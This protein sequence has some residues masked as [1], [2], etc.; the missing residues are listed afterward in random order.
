MVDWHFCQISWVFQYCQNQNQNWISCGNHSKLNK[1]SKSHYTL[2]IE[3]ITLHFINWANHISL[4]KLI[5]SHVIAKNDQITFHC[6]NW[7]NHI[8][9]QKLIKSHYTILLTRDKSNN[10]NIT[11]SMIYGIVIVEPVHNG[12]SIVAM[13]TTLLRNPMPK[14]VIHRK[15]V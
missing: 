3:Q 6:K 4:Q 5:K 11:P 10:A 12:A 13:P 7:S 1:L 2:C 15:H 14:P 9:L 8:S